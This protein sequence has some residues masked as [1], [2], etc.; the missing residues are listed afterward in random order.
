[1]YLESE[2]RFRIS[3]NGLIGGVVFANAETFSA[4]RGTTFQQI[5]PGYGTGIRVK[6]KKTS[7]TNIGIDYGVGTQGSKGLFINVGEYF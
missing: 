2:Y 6:L 1:M 3:R 7:G 5:Q 4:E